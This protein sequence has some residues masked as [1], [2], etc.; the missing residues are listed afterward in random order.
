[1]PFFILGIFL[2][3]SRGCT[4]PARLDNPVRKPLSGRWEGE[5]YPPYNAL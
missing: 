4:W 2:G 1:M 5:G 3:P